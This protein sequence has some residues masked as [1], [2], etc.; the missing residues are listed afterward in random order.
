MKQ[1]FT[2]DFAIFVDDLGGLLWACK[3]AD[4]STWEEMGHV[5]NAAPVTL[6]KLANRQ[7]KNP[8]MYTCWKVLRGMDHSG[9]IRHSQLEK[10]RGMA[11]PKKAPRKAAKVIP[12]KKPAVAA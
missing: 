11:G 8:T 7:T 2:R 6:R 1:N 12:L 3:L 9:V 4:R 5:I 10:Y